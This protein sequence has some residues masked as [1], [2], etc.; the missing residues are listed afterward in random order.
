M[1]ATQPVLVRLL[2][3]AAWVYVTMSA[4]PLVPAARAVAITNAYGGGAKIDMPDDFYDPDSN[5]IAA[6]SIAGDGGDNGR[7]SASAFAYGPTPNSSNPLG[8]FNILLRA[9]ALASWS[10]ASSNQRPGGAAFAEWTDQLKFKNP[11]EVDQLTFEDGFVH[12]LPRVDGMI[13]ALGI[14][15]WTVTVGDQSGGYDFDKQSERRFGSLDFP[16]RAS[17]LKTGLVTLTMTLYVTTSTTPEYPFSAAEFTNTAVL[18]PLILADADGNYVPGTEQLQI[19]GTSGFEYLV[20]AVPEP[21]TAA[22]LAL[23]GVS[24]LSFRGHRRRIG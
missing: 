14:A 18:P 22:L 12:F 13:T 11:D 6:A 1:N 15:R 7:W 24:L 21:A 4:G 20:A 2:A 19:V 23:G 16:I 10:G 3:L 17:E 5:I 9:E 8:P